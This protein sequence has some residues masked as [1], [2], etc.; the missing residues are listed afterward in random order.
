MKLKLFLDV[1]NET[2]GILLKDGSLPSL[3]ISESD[4]LGKSVLELY[5]EFI[6]QDDFFPLTRPV[7]YQK[8]GEIVIC[9][10]IIVTVFPKWLKS[11]QIHNLTEVLQRGP[12]DEAVLVIQ[13]FR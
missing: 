7:V 12:N 6:S 1:V 10:R 2:R 9:Y 4:D 3:C 13:S 5:R 8:D 11:G